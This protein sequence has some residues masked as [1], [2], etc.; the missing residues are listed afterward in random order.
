[1]RDATVLFA[2]AR[3]HDRLFVALELLQRHVGT[4][5]RRGC[6][7]SSSVRPSRVH[8]GD[9]WQ[10]SSEELVLGGAPHSGQTSRKRWISCRWRAAR[11]PLGFRVPVQRQ[12]S[13]RDRQCRCAPVCASQVS[14]SPAAN[15]AAK[16]SKPRSRSYSLRQ[17]AMCAAGSSRRWNRSAVRTVTH[18]S[19][20]PSRSTL[21]RWTVERGNGAVAVM[22]AAVNTAA[23]LSAAS[24]QCSAECPAGVI[25]GRG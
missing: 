5:R 4:M 11:N 1:M 14:S 24:A 2:R 10:R 17:S 21:N 12:C 20:E 19:G 25:P 6:R 9:G 15:A 22:S 7:S 13:G 18:P 16:S 3:G 23:T 8:Q